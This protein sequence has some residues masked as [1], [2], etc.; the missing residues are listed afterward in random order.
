MKNKQTKD[1]WIGAARHS[2]GVM[3]FNGESL[4]KDLKEAAK[5]FRLAA[6]QGH[7]TA[8]LALNLDEEVG[9]NF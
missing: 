1:S 8:K 9:L 2:L 3:Y 4:P 7:A 6:E 5:W